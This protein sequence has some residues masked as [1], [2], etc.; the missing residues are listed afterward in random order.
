MSSTG[1]SSGVRE[2]DDFYATPGWCTKA[3]LPFVWLELTRTKREATSPLHVLDPCCGEGAILDIVASSTTPFQRR[4]VAHGIE[5]DRG[6][7]KTAQEKHRLVKEGDAHTTSWPIVDIILTNPPYS[8]AMAFVE[9]ALKECDV[10]CM[11]LRMQWLASAGRS[12]FH[13]EHPSRL[14][15]LSTR[16]SFAWTYRCHKEDGGCGWSLSC[17]PGESEAPKR[18]V[19]A[20]LHAQCCLKGKPALRI[21]KNDLADY[22]WFLWSPDIREGEWMILPDIDQPVPFFVDPPRRLR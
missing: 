12:A 22:A 16:P 8:D 17:P 9:Y 19:R 13:K 18:R 21:T 14:H 3:I 7:A 5:L 4:A 1:R 6:R 10:V 2:K 20:A 15:I 11:L